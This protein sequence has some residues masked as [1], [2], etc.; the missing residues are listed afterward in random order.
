MSDSHIFVFLFPGGRRSALAS[1]TDPGLRFL[2]G[3]VVLT[4]W[5]DVYVN[6]LRSSLA[7]GA[8]SML[9]AR[10]RERE[11]RMMAADTHI[12]EPESLGKF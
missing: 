10:G 3:T 6:F 4:G 12:K 1:S 11:A 7:T 5:K 2:G 8:R 9:G